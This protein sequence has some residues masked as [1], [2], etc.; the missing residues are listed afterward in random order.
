MTMV[1]EAFPASGSEL[2]CMLAMADWA[3]DEG[4]SLHPSMRS[5]AEKVRVS[6]KQARRIVKSLVA[7]GFLEVVGNAYGGAPGATKNWVINVKKLK[8]LVAE[9]EAENSQTPPMGVTP[10][11]NVTPPMGV[12]VPLPPVSQT[13]PMGGSQTTIEPP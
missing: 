6:E 5:I 10:P 9:K 4:R 8:Q 1:W 13:P 7:D 12:H 11:A 3:N 2:L